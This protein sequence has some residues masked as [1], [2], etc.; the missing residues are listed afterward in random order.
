MSRSDD[1]R[2]S[3]EQDR[4]E[5]RS[6]AQT[7]LWT[8][9]NVL[10][11][12]RLLGAP[13]LVALAWYGASSAFIVV[14]LV[15]IGTDWID[16]RLA[17]WLDQRSSFGAKLDTV[18]DVVLF[19]ALLVGGVILE[20]EF[21][22]GNWPWIAAAPAS[23]AASV[24]VSWLR[25]GRLPSYHTRIAKLS[26]YLVIFGAVLVIADVTPWLFRVAMLSVA[27]GNLEAIGITLALP[28]PR[29][30]VLS[31]PAALRIRRSDQGRETTDD[32]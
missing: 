26:S 9:P 14:L 22:L 3:R 29:A 4:D 6:T 16:G 23:Y 32:R 18:A 10:C 25:F 11:L 8:I 31:L 24:V 28:K 17:R 19:G 7:R 5:A 27:I 12:A 30:D 15:L 21:L 1:V 2:K 13:L 20:H